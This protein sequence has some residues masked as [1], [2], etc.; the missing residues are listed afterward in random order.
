MSRFLIGLLSLMFALVLPGAA[1]AQ[2]TVPFEFAK[3]IDTETAVPGTSTYFSSFGPPQISDGKVYFVGTHMVPDE[4][5]RN[6]PVDGLYVVDQDGLHAV[7]DFTTA[8]PGDKKGRYLE[9]F[10]DF[11]VANGTVVFSAADSHLDQENLYMLKDGQ[12]TI[13]AGRDQG[14]DEIKG[15]KFKHFGR[16]LFDGERLLFEGGPDP[17]SSLILYQGGHYYEIAGEGKKRRRKGEPRTYVQLQR[18]AGFDWDGE[19]VVFGGRYFTGSN[20]LADEARLMEFKDGEIHFFSY[21]EG[22][23]PN[24]ARFEELGSIVLD[25]DAIAFTGIDD[26]ADNEVRWNPGGLYMLGDAGAE[27]IADRFF[28]PWTGETTTTPE[29]QGGYRIGGA[30]VMV[31]RFYSDSFVKTNWHTIK[32]LFTDT[33]V[34]GLLIEDN[35]HG[36]T[37]YDGKRGQNAGHLPYAFREDTISGKATIRTIYVYNSKAIV[38]TNNYILSPMLMAH[39]NLVASPFG[40]IF[41]AA[42]LESREGLFLKTADGVAKI[43]ADDDTLFDETVQHLFIGRKAVE[44]EAFVFWAATGYGEDMI[45]HQAIVLATP[46]AKP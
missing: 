1:L 4:K 6:Q 36:K 9:R 45:E 11:A 21:P 13:L 26:A 40:V 22:G 31:Y 17:D 29:P 27:V 37:V 46:A 2:D 24:V 43:V 3:V 15:I 5:G 8:I 10:L 20:N 16:I 35:S 7:I 32:S 41:H 23:V 28:N 44:G 12:L 34:Y 39:G 18:I 19:R 25:G 42:N 30:N 33:P 14:I 38:D